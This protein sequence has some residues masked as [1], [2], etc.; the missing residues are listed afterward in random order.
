[1]QKTNIAPEHWQ[2][3][4]SPL[5][6]E[7][8]KCSSME[9]TFYCSAA[10]TFIVVSFHL[11]LWSM[12]IIPA[13]W[14]DNKRKGQGEPSE[15]GHGFYS[16]VFYSMSW[17][18]AM[19]DRANKSENA[20][21]LSKQSEQQCITALLFLSCK[22]HGIWHLVPQCSSNSFSHILK[23]CSWILL[24]IILLHLPECTDW[25]IRP[26][27]RTGNAEDWRPSMHRLHDE[28]S[29]PCSTG[30]NAQTWRVWFNITTVMGLWFSWKLVIIS[31]GNNKYS[32]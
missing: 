4:Q 24:W 13:A 28:G 10:L 2:S 14:T 6:A 27:A 20:S 5:E 16:R 8:V 23:R 19:H 31:T 11:W 30:E 25:A 17:A 32:N 3:W 22:T 12:C 1:M 9:W 15:K 29:V 26:E 21:V 7:N 18:S